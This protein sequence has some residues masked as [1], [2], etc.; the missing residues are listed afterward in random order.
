MAWLGSTAR[1][2]GEWFP[3]SPEGC[4]LSDLMLRAP[5]SGWGHWGF[6]HLFCIATGIPICPQSPPPLFFCQ[7]LLFGGTH[8]GKQCNSWF[9]TDQHRRW[10][11]NTR[12][13]KVIRLEAVFKI[14]GQAEMLKWGSGL[15]TSGSSYVG[16]GQTFIFFPF[17]YCC[18]DSGYYTMLG[19]HLEII[20]S[21]VG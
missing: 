1:E 5:S 11:M 7:V 6:A 12:K 14:S 2:K 18:L 16:G 17:L 10:M 3:L 19:T 20:Q 15:W 13:K 4:G 8:K 21:A 9:S